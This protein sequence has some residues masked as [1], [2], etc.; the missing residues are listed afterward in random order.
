MN[1]AVLESPIISPVETQPAG[2]DLYSS[3]FDFTIEQY[4]Q[5][6]EVGILDEGT[7]CELLDEIVLRKNR[8]DEGNR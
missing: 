2:E 5:L 7:P 3:L 4:Q 1:Q 6:I 8:A